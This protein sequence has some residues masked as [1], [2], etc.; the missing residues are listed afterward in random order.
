MSNILFL[1]N[2]TI[3]PI[4][5]IIK[6]LG[7]E[8]LNERIEKI[9]FGNYD[10]VVTESIALV[11][12]KSQ[13]TSPDLVVLA[14]N[15]DDFLGGPW[16]SSWSVQHVL[17]ELKKIYSILMEKPDSK[18]LINTFLIS[19]VSTIMPI[20]NYDRS[21]EIRE[22]NNYI[23]NFVISHSD[24]FLLADWELLSV[25]IGINNVY[26]PR[27]RWMKNAPFKIPFLKEYAE[28]VCRSLVNLRGLAK[29]VIVTDADN[30]LWG[31]VV[32][33][34][35][36]EHINLD[37]FEYPGR[38]FHIYQSELLSLKRQGILLT[39]C[40]KNNEQDVF[41][42][43]DNHPHCLI[44]KEDLA[45]CQINWQDKADNIIV[46][47]EKLNIGLDAFVFVDDNPAECDRVRRALPEVTVLKVPQNPSS[48]P[49]F[50]LNQP[51]FNFIESTSEDSTRTK[52]YQEQEIRTESRAG[53]ETRTEF[54][55]SL[56]LKA[57]V[58]ILSN[59]QVARVAQLTQ[60]TNQFNLTTKRYSE[61][62]IIRMKE[63]SEIFITTLKVKDRFGDLG[64]TGVAIF[65]KENKSIYVD[66]FLLSC[67]IIGRDLEDF[68][69]L[70][71]L[72]LFPPKWKSTTITA[73]YRE[74]AK[75]SQVASLW[76]RF[77]LKRTKN[78]KGVV[79]Y[80]T[81]PKD[82]KVSKPKYIQRIS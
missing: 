17:A 53:F 25:R 63:L 28:L 37:A 35:G 54:L 42:V 20:K 72:K 71:C 13:E 49:G 36:F 52:K 22:I 78:V 32:G 46:I 31:G 8:I 29:K 66:T 64:L 73:S 24:Q 57:T 3:E 7:K 81:S 6:K 48:I 26:D 68:F 56:K 39:L 69:F 30:T 47:S 62:E 75:N 65:K 77:G 11:Q 23:R 76:D 70:E 41:N 40:S 14:L 79:H 45:V 21:P 59:D 43:F 16:S 58:S 51:I 38:C 12:A 74:T 50:I 34:D 15:L 2:F 67:R 4:A 9:K 1:R 82:L 5:P 44:T 18:V 80:S 60:R 27:L 55:F 33:E 19:G 61:S 10:N